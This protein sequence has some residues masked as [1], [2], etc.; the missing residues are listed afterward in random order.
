MWLLA[1]NIGPLPPCLDLGWQAIK[2]VPRSPFQDPKSVG[3]SFLQ[4]V[5][6]FISKSCLAWLWCRGWWRWWAKEPCSPVDFGWVSKLATNTWKSRFHRR[7]LLHRAL[8]I[9]TTHREWEI[10]FLQCRR[11]LSLH[12]T[13][14]RTLMTIVTVAHCI[15]MHCSALQQHHNWN[16]WSQDVTGCT[17]QPT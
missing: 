13:P 9:L 7:F 15:A 11:I 2:S 16:S 17:V 1:Q 10:R 3:S 4:I 12:I 5:W 14:C 6:K 8:H